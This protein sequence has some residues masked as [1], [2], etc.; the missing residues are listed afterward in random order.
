M[1]TDTDGDSVP[2]YLESNTADT[3]Q[4]GIT[5][6]LD[7]DDDGDGVPTVEEADDDPAPAS[8]GGGGGY[9]YIPPLDTDGDGIPDYLD[10][11]DDGDG[12]PTKDEQGDTDSDTL[13]DYRE[14]DN[15]DLDKD[16][17]I[18][19]MDNDDDGDGILSRLDSDPYSQ[20]CYIPAELGYSLYVVNPDG[21]K[22]T[23]RGY[24]KQTTVGKNTVRYDF[25][26]GNDNDFN[27]LAVRV[28]DEGHRSFIVTVM[29][30]EVRNGYKVHLEILGDSKVEQDLTL[31]TNPRAAVNV[32]KRIDVQQYIEIC[33]DHKDFCPAH[34]TRYMRK[35][36]NNDPVEVSKLQSFLVEQEG[37][38]SVQVNG[39]F[40]DMTDVAVRQFQE[41]HSGL[42]LSPW[43][44]QKG[45]GYVYRTTTKRINDL[46]CDSKNDL[47]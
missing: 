16:G 25:E 14:S 12:T 24:S 13:P 22:R 37:N 34:I 9:Y 18:D 35:G 27:D 8:S 31:W 32:P 1:I 42:I 36:A 29:N 23:A 41:K 6:N 5:N 21:T 40:D 43:A 2:D 7:S 30:S 28:N 20:T 39:V 46:Y 15:R 38:T 3:D 19:E 11:D 10:T 45:T 33:G 47:R 44:I 17:K 26:L 4:D